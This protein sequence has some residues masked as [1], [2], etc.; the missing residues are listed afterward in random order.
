M[1]DWIENQVVLV[2]W[3]IEVFKNL[4]RH[5]QNN[6]Q[7]V[8]RG[9]YP[10]LTADK[11]VNLSRAVTDDE[12]KLAL[13]SMGSWKALALMAP[14]YVFSNKLGICEGFF[15]YLGQKSLPEPFFEILG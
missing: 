11:L 8:V 14:S 12:I 3:R 9:A 13:F 1:G 2:N 6:V 4:F 15:V 5:N 10:N 7:Y